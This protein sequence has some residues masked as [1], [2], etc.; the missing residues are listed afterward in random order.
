MLSIVIFALRRTLAYAAHLGSVRHEIT[1][2]NRRVPVQSPA[3]RAAQEQDS[4]RVLF[5]EQREE[6]RSGELFVGDFGGRWLRSPKQMHRHTQDECDTAVEVE[7]EVER[8]SPQRS[9]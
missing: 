2:G 4:S 9:P 1:D 7:Q 3:F 5:L 6:A 8:R